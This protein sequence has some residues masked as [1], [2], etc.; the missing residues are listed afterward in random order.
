[1][2]KNKSIYR[3]IHADN[4]HC[5]NN[6]PKWLFVNKQYNCKQLRLHH[7]QLKKYRRPLII[8]IIHKSPSFQIL[9]SI[10]YCAQHSK[11]RRIHEMINIL[12]VN[13]AKVPIIICL[14]SSFPLLIT[15]IIRII[16]RKPQIVNPWNESSVRIPG[17]K[18]IG[19]IT[20]NYGR[21]RNG[22]E[23]INQSRSVRRKHD[24]TWIE[25]LYLLFKS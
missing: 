9:Y 14:F 15:F 19:R 17:L 3:D 18:I 21:V 8:Y 13:T 5:V 22:K 16:C 4:Q 23:Q 10:S 24:I 11:L 7:S 2:N 20:F 12:S 1:M 6:K 25:S